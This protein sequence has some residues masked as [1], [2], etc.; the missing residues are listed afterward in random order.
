MPTA[1]STER[2]SMWNLPPHSPTTK[3][4]G[5]YREGTGKVQHL[6]VESAA[7]LAHYDGSEALFGHEAPLP[8]PDRAQVSGEASLAE[9]RLV[10]HGGSVGV[11][12]VHHL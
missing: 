8:V 11:R 5:R 10:V 2:T 1:I 3:V 4:Q 6:H 7:P 12:A 9:L